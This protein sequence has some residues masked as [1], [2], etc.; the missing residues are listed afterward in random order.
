MRKFIVSALFALCSFLSWVAC[1][2][3][4]IVT[5]NGN[6]TIGQ[7]C[8]AAAG[9]SDAGGGACVTGAVCSVNYCRT[10]CTTDHDCNGAGSVCLS[11]PGGGGCRLD[12]EA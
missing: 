9:S 4:D 3:N 10:A 12:R 11:G 5:G 6:T 2:S 1:K 8:N 7:Q